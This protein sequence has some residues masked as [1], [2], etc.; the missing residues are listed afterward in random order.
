MS[1]IFL[2]HGPPGTGK[3]RYLSRQAQRAISEHGAENVAIASL[4]RTAAAEISGRNSNIPDQNVG[5]L[6]SACFH[7]LGRPKLAETPEGL[8]AWNAEHPALELTGGRTGLEDAPVEAEGG[9]RTR[10]DELHSAVANHRARRTPVEAWSDDEREYHALWRDWCAQTDRLDFT[11]L[12]ERAV[13]ELDAHPAH[14]AVLLLDEAQDFSALELAL[15]Q[16]WAQHAET[17]VIAG[18]TDQALYQ[19]RGSDPGALLSTPRAGERVLEQSYRVPAAVHELAMRWIGQIQGRADVAYRPTDVAGEVRRLPISLRRP[20]ALLD[21]IA[22]DVDAGRSVMILTSC[23]YMLAPILG[24][25]KRAGVPFGNPHRITAGQWNPLRAGGR[26]LA[27]LTPRVTRADWTWDELRRWTEPLQARGTLSRGAKT[28][29]EE[30]CRAD[31]FGESRADQRPDAETVRNLFEADA[32]ERAVR[33]DVDWWAEHLLAKDAKTAAYPVEIYRRHG[34]MAL[35]APP[36]VTVGTIHSVKGGEADS[37]YLF[38]DLS[39]TGYWTGWHPGG[40]GRDQIVRMLYVALTRARERVTILDPSG[41]EHV[42]LELLG[43]GDRAPER[44]RTTLGPT[45]ARA[46]A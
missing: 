41:P 7:A 25:L 30:K 45:F 26:L 28:F 5:T 39:R 29:I 27:F 33:C 15:A 19:W 40:P 3:T 24:L 4:T 18:D 8:R 9:G 12:I 43:G 32:W 11:D 2:V 1:N 21:E 37:V 36:A 35:A 34:A 6:H 31:K 44:V 13:A 10:G 23:G 46:A 20:E 16:R 38:P 17:T 22:A 42:P 14:P